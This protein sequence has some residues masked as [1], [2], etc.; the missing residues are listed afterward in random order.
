VFTIPYY[1]VYHISHPDGIAHG[2]A[3]VIIPSAID[4]HELLH[5]QSDKIQAANIQ[6]D[7]NTRPFT[8]SAIYCS[9]RHV[10]SAEEYIALFQPLGTKFQTDGDWNA[11]HKEWGA[12]LTTP[13]RRNLLYAINRQNCKYLNTGEPTDCPLNPNKLPDLLDFFILHGITSNNMQVES[14]F[15]ISS[16]HSPV[17]VT[18][19][20]HVI[21]KS[22][23]PTLITK[24]T[25][26]ANI[27]TYI[28]THINLKQTIEEPNELDEANQ[29]FTTLIQEAAWRSA[30]N[31]KEE[32]QELDNI[33]SIY[34]SCWN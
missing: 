30:H 2:G 34:E 32:R 11:K 10:M 31:S 22:T 24:Q 18:I 21:S 25:N 13:K 23:I 12:R 20:A 16:D 15:E 19:S 33:P 3:T 27:R 17:I 9:P 28:E 7:A 4:H 26:R 5:N 8:I 29:Y 1:K 14:R 6:G